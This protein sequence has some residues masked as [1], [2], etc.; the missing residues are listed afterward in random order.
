MFGFAVY[1][2]LPLITRELAHRHPGLTV[3]Q[4]EEPDRDAV[5]HGRVDVALGTPLELPTG[6]SA[7]LWRTHRDDAGIREFSDAARTIAANG[8]SRAP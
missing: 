6:L 2:L 3:T 8:P 7:A 1:R 5:L 4:A